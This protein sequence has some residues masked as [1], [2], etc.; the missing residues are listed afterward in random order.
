ME[1]RRATGRLRCLLRRSVTVP[2]LLVSLP[3]AAALLLVALVCQL[4]LLL[5]GRRRARPVRL[6]ALLL[7]YVLADLGGL[8]AAT[9]NWLRCL[10]RARGAERRAELD[11][12][13]LGRLLRIVHGAGA[14]LFDLRLRVR[15]DPAGGGSTGGAGP[16]G[17]LIVLARHAG[18]GDSFLLVDQLLSAAGYR[19]RIVLKQ[20]LRLDP[21]LDVLLG[22][23]PSCFVPPGGGETDATVARITELAA[24]LRDGDALVIFPEGGNFTQRRRQR[25]I[26]RLRRRGE[27]ARVAHAERDHHVLPPRMAGTLAAL[28]AAPTADVVFVAHTGL[29]GMDSIGTVW[30]GLPLTRP[31]RARWWRVPARAV[32]TGRQ[33]REAWLLAHWDRVDAWVAL[34]RAAG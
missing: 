3:A 26:R 14:R 7:L 15:P 4:P 16:G 20:R 9:V 12:R 11:H 21:T 10:G 17:P 29:D 6:A 27:R 33:A 30:R 8:L 23:L 25:A 18:P 22:R 1:G 2:L 24:G 5:L 31:V 34:N 13:L 28:A 19:P 32:P